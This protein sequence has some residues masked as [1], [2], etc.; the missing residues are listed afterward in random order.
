MDQFR[1]LYEFAASAGAFEG[2]VYPKDAVDP[3]Y[4]PRWVEHLV[5]A[6]HMLDEE[7]RQKIQPS[8]DKT[9]GRAI[10]SLIPKLGEH[11]EVIKKLKTMVEEKNLPESPDD[12][13]K[14][15]WFENREE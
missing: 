4:L 6:Y 13:E 1:Q 8:L 14:E 10:K 15:K 9:L 7:V 11:D 12:F 3:E 2:Y 5:T